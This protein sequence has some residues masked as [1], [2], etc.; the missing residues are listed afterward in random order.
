M[1]ALRK[2]AAR[3][4]VDGVLLL[5]KPAGLSS[6]GALQRARRLFEAEK[7]GHTGTL[8]PLASGLLPVCF[9]EATKFARFLLDARK[10]YHA[11]V[12]FGTT[13]RTQD[14]E[15]EV[16]ETRPVALDR[17][18]VA[19]AL[20]GFVGVLR[21]VPPAYSALKLKGRSYYEYGSA[22]APTSGPTWWRTWGPSCARCG[23]RWW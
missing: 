2:R 15:G 17:G 19:A 11:V 18:D 5:D 4:R 9:G 8:D 16:L 13:T 1:E 20:P 12:R 21:Q 3:R 23:R 14:A 6:N 22:R 10:R 7:A